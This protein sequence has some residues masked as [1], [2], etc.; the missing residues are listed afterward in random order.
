MVQVAPRGPGGAPGMMVAPEIARSDGR[1][2]GRLGG[3]LPFAAL[4]TV[5]SDTQEADLREGA[6]Q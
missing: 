1:V 6:H 5:G 4:R 2:L 3:K